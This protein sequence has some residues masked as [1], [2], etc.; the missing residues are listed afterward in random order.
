MLK[1]DDD[2]PF[3]CIICI[4]QNNADIFPFG[5]LSKSEMLDLSGIDMPSQLPMLPFYKTRDDLSVIK[6][7]F[8]MVCVELLS[9]AEKILYVVVV[10]NTQTLMYKNS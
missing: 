1:E 2:L 7:D 4:I 6:D 8:E 3:N 10:T 9:Q 5:Y